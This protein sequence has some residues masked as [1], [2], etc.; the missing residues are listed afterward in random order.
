[1][2]HILP[3]IKSFSSNT[4]QKETMAVSICVSLIWKL[5]FKMLTDMKSVSL[6][7]STTSSHYS[8]EYLITTLPDT[9]VDENKSAGY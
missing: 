4:L 1:M 9:H 8:D 7:L 5:V 3:N 2:L 6:L